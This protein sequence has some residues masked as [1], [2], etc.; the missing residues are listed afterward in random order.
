[1]PVDLSH[2][3][4]ILPLARDQDRPPSTPAPPESS[5]PASHH[6]PIRGQRAIQLRLDQDVVTQLVHLAKSKGAT[7]GK[8]L[9]LDLRPGRP[10]AIVIDGVA[11]LLELNPEPPHSEILRVSPSSRDLEPIAT[12]SHRAVSKTDSKA[13]RMAKASLNLKASREKEERE[14]ESKKAVLLDAAPSSSRASSLSR[15]R[16]SQLASSPPSRTA[17][18]VT[19]ASASNSSSQPKHAS[20]LIATGPKPPSS[21]SS[22]RIGKGSL[23]VS[24]ATARNSSS[25]STSSSSKEATPVASPQ[26][27]LP[28]AAAVVSEQ[29]PK[30]VQPPPSRQFSSSSTSSTASSESGGKLLS[31][32][33]S[34]SS[35]LGTSPES[36]VVPLGSANKLNLDPGSTAGGEGTGVG[37]TTAKRPGGGGVLMGKK[38]LKKEAKK[39]NGKGSTASN[40]TKSSKGKE[41]QVEEVSDDVDADG[42]I[43]EEMV[44]GDDTADD[45]D[46]RSAANNAKKKRKLLNGLAVESRST[47]R[48]KGKGRSSDREKE[49]TNHIKTVVKKVV[50]T[51]AS[52]SEGRP[53]VEAGQRSR[54]PSG[55]EKDRTREQPAEKIG[56]RELPEK[57]KKRKKQ[58]TSRW[59]SSDSDE[60]E[61]GVDNSIGRLAPPG[62]GK[63]HRATVDA[64]PGRP[65]PPPPPP[66]TTLSASSPTSHAS[67][68]ARFYEL[69]APYA[70]LHSRL[71]S[72]R[73]SLEL[74]QPIQESPKQLTALVEECQKR[75]S[76]LERLKDSLQ[77]R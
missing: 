22:F 23:P 19:A 76:E 18:P 50:S 69:Y 73:A 42:E 54:E 58:E 41:K 72:I 25:S 1:M 74:G 3:R 26:L 7:A 11:H 48:D 32:A 36:I 70:V 53:S 20:R 63:Q 35:T 39:S 31:S 29:P 27:P 46:G 62:G 2:P 17:S 49:R 28:R 33:I 37:T 24:I 30:T 45:D 34:N 60:G 71:S 13:E 40:A 47:S 14:K 52:E 51:T 44:A 66:A 43:D 4:R 65:P 57:S 16:P 59:Y 67:K 10:P 6:A 68:K 61:G 64:P 5:G 15:T 8:K 21:S 38:S 56:G 55:K 75:R 12:I 77:R 9:Q